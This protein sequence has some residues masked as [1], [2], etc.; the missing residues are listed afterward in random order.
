[1]R[2]IRNIFINSL[3]IE[4]LLMF[5]GIFIITT[6]GLIFFNP[7]LTALYYGGIITFVLYFLDL[8]GKYIRVLGGE[9]DENE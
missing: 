8:F 1:M 3:L 2:T 5:A 4:N 9:E 6:I 7:F